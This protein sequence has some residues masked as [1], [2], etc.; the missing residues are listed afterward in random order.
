MLNVKEEKVLIDTYV[1]AERENLPMF[2]ENRVHQRTSGNPY[3]NKV[4][5]V[6]QREIKKKCEYTCL[7]LENDYLE[8]GILPDLGGKIWYAKDKI[9]D[10]G[11]FYKN[12]VI[13]PALIGVLGSWTSGGLEFNWPFHHRASTFMPVDYYIEKTDKN[14]TVWMSEHDPINR[15]K[16]MVGVSLNENECV[17]ETKVKVDNITPFRHSFLWW[18][19]AAV[20]VDENYRIFFPKDVSYVRFHYKRSVTTYPIANND[21]F[22]A[23]NGIYYDGDTDISAH[24]NTRQ[25]TSYF[26]AE[27]KYDYFG[28]YDDAK[29][30]GV[31][32]IADRHISP[33]K[34]MFTWA[35]SQ[36]AKTWENALTDNDGQYAELMAGCYSD[37]QP[38]L[39]WLMPNETKIFS[40]KWFPIHDSG[41]PVFANE[42]GAIFEDNGK[43]F[44][45]SVR[46]L[47]NAK[48][49]VFD[50]ECLIHEEEVNI[51]CY[52]NTLVY[53][54]FA[55]NGMKIVVSDEHEVLFSYEIKDEETQEIP[56]PRKELPY[57]KNVKTAQELYLEGLHIEQYRS[58]EYSA[59]KCYLEALE[60]DGEYVP[61]LTA[62][63]ELC[64]KKHDGVN[65][66]EYINRAEKAATRFNA[67]L[68]S[69]KIYYLKGLALCSLQ[70]F[71]K[72]YDYL[73]KS[74]WCYDY[75]SAATL[76]IGLLDI[77][78]KSYKKAIWH[79]NE[80]LQGNRESVIALVFLGY[81]HN[82]LGDKQ[83]AEECF[84]EAI[85][86]DKL[87]L[88]SYA[89]KA[90]ID[91][92]YNNF[93]S[94]LHTDATQVSMDIIELFAEAGLY[95]EISNWLNAS[96]QIR[97]LGAIEEY[98]LAWVDEKTV[99]KE[100]IGIAF[101]SR[102]LEKY[103][104]ENAVEKSPNDA[105]ALYLY[106]CLSYGK[107]LYQEGINAWEKAIKSEDY[108][109][110][111]NLAVAY[112]SRYNNGLKALEYM[113][114]ASELSPYEEKQITFETAYLMA[115][116]GVSPIEITDYIL[117][118]DYNRDDIVV[119]LARSY[120]HANMPDKAL[121]VLLGRN[122]V[123]CEGGEHAIAD[124]YT[125]A[126]Y[127]KGKHAYEKQDYSYAV[128]CFRNAQVLP[129]SLGSG[130]WNEIKKVP[131]QYF[132][133]RCLEKLNK[134]EDAERIFN[135]FRKY[136][137][138]YFTDMYL[139]TFA[140]YS[141]QSL[142]LLG[143]KDSAD[144]LIA[145]R[146]NEYYNAMNEETL[147]YFGTTPF[148]ISFIDNPQKARKL[149]YS[150]PLYLFECYLGKEG[151]E[152]KEQISSDKY[153]LYI[154]DFTI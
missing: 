50:E 134:R 63:A 78:N 64:L 74:A 72:G 107:G 49:S 129:Q 79:F 40:Q 150:Y 153:G 85:E 57:F 149:H 115:K 119:E 141:A 18:E 90:M 81:I 128:E 113:K 6:A 52:T 122:F 132:E 123:A 1:E 70:Q 151:K 65:A 30:A 75:R 95:K 131:F 34:K 83:K 109:V 97:K 43:L 59:E 25:A 154:E 145:K 96:K 66:L 127:L 53:E 12:N 11:F 86:R 7:V 102:S 41:V 9:N 103:V 8:I 56:E 20:P 104:L 15:M 139:Y 87:N 27:S 38:D 48:I 88:F 69:G 114:K 24:K 22:G 51:P 54:N 112:Y 55:K 71:E 130:F 142:R 67:R 13:K 62:L 116:T 77:R 33:G 120:N 138:D 143:E 99:N 37:N 106:G 100:E 42:N 137:Y 21:R 2:A 19:N 152:Y 92:N 118:R 98:V 136:K 73:Q 110:Y 126:Y 46:G 76:H 58:P 44:L 60:R 125:Y 91:G 10:Y 140:Y 144:C 29:K 82:I 47:N 68:E 148:F 14:V 31:V 108:R 111:R 135:S 3:P 32:H 121:E 89:F 36:L 35:Y 146:I 16:G 84:K 39:T 124:E 117:S 23:F 94:N 4:V 61:A 17:F 28:G 105:N 93:Y 26:S 80:S 5:Q 101:P 45:Q 133:A 147:G